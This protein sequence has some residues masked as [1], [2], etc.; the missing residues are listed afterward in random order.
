MAENVM[1]EMTPGTKMKISKSLLHICK[2]VQSSPRVSIVY[3]WKFRCSSSTNF[4]RKRK[5]SIYGPQLTP[6]LNENSDPLLHYLQD[7]PNHIQEDHL[8]ILGIT[9]LTC[10]LQRSPDLTFVWGLVRSFGRDLRQ[11]IRGPNFT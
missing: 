11:R 4:Y 1:F 7:I 5:T 9:L 10:M 3:S 2:N 6:R 8:S